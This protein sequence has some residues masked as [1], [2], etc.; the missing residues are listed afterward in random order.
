LCA[1]LLCIPKILKQGV[2]ENEESYQKVLK[3]VERAMR[4]EAKQI[5]FQVNKSKNAWTF[6]RALWL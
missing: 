6:G 4:N 1:V 2:K 3:A 5:L